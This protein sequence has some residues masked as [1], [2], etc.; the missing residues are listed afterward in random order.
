VDSARLLFGGLG[1]I[2]VLGA[3]AAVRARPA[4]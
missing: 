3:L 2:A 1:A 4:L